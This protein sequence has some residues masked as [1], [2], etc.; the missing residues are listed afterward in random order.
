MY[1]INII[2]VATLN[3]Y[4]QTDHSCHSYGK[5]VYI[6]MTSYVQKT[7][8]QERMSCY[9]IIKKVR[10][11]ITWEMLVLAAILNFSKIKQVTSTIFWK[12]NIKWMRM[13]DSE[14]LKHIKCHVKFYFTCLMDLIMQKTSPFWQP[15]WISPLYQP[16]A[17]SDA[18]NNTGFRFYT[19]FGHR[20]TGFCVLFR[21]KVRMCPPLQYRIYL[22]I[23]EWLG[24]KLWKWSGPKILP[25][26]TP[27]LTGLRL[28]DWTFER[29][30][31]FSSCLSSQIDK[32]QRISVLSVFYCIHQCHR[33]FEV[34]YNFISPDWLPN[35]AML[36]NL[37]IFCPF[38]QHEF[39]QL[40]QI[41]QPNP[42]FLSENKIINS[43]IFSFCT[44]IYYNIFM[45]FT[46][47]KKY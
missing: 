16:K 39:K 10:I 9:D 14:T 40:C 26:G 12:K 1:S 34:T 41:R 45:I 27:V 36:P 22:I 11:G 4:G 5:C 21:K 43:W 24:Q 2:L 31:F 7:P 32:I 35:R 37:A 17:S 33:S 44:F 30:F 42:K 15:F 38:S 29:E 8:K 47:Q 6:K 3:S 13:L 46:G 20:K 25:C 28:C 18:K 23:L 19:K